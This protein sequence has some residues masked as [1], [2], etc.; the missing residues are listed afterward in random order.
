MWCRVLMLL[1]CLAPMAGC[2]DSST[3]VLEGEVKLDPDVGTDVNDP[4]AME[5]LMKKSPA[6]PK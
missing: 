2:A 3:R 5:K 6:P 4:A 1:V